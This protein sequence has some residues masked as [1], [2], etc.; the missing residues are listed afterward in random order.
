MWSTALNGTVTGLALIIAIGAQ[1]AFVLRQ[2]IRREHITAVVAI[3]IASDA[4]LITAGTA[5]IGAIVD[6]VP[7][8]LTVL[9]WAG[10]A[11]LLWFAISSIRSAIKPG[12][13]TAEAPRSAG[14]VAAT[15]VA[16]T[17]LNPHVYLDTVLFLGSMANQHGPD[18]RWVYATG[19]IVGSIIWFT[20]LGFGARALARP[21]ADPK[22]WR[23]LDLIIAAVMIVLAIKLAFF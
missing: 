19:A 23:V 9:R 10:A 1:N 17:W 2:G 6:S 15:A 12:V 20:A 11:Y 22:A 7:W 3:C 18:G 5:G 8:L 13:L 14:S 4:I 16:L 21:L